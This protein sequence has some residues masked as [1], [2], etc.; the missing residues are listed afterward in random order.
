MA[1][2]EYFVEEFD[3]QGGVPGAPGTIPAGS[4]ITFT[5]RVKKSTTG[6]TIF[7]RAKHTFSVTTA[8]NISVTAADGLYV[9]VGVNVTA[10]RNKLVS[11]GGATAPASTAAGTFDVIE[12]G[13][14]QP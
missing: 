6:G 8:S 10:A 13:R 1:A 2:G 11:V 12:V 3:T 5:P 9:R 4:T 14:V 7:P